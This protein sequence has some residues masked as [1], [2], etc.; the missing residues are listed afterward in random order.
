M[1]VGMNKAAMKRWIPARATLLTLALFLGSVAVG[2]GVL[3]AIAARLERRAVS[4]F[5]AA[6]WKEQVPRSA[7]GYRDYDYPA[8]RPEGCYR[9]LAVG[10]S[11]TAGHGINFDDA[12]PK[13]LE[14]YLNYFGNKRRT[15]YQVLNLGVNGQSTPEEVRLIREKVAE[16]GPDLVILGYCLNDPEDT[17]QPAELKALQ[18]R[19]FYVYF[20]TPTTGWSGFLYRRSALYRLI[21]HRLFATMSRR[22]AKRYYQALYNDDY[23]GWQKSR[24]ALRELGEFSRQSG[25]PVVTVIFPLFFYGLGDDYPFATAH[26]KVAAVLREA[27]IPYLDLWESFKGLDAESLKAVPGIDP[28]PNEVGHR[29]A[30]EALWRW[31]ILKDYLPS[32]QKFINLV[33]PI[34]SPFAG[35]PA[36]PA[37]AASSQRRRK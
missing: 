22:G 13:R 24:A 37:R 4:P 14:R 8:A 17:G 30:A 23:P 32:R 36:E 19:M 11:Y 21:R 34:P 12:Y 1:Q 6:R 3:E 25:I 16:L 26:R 20:N 27:G 31:L 35:A 2:L 5:P 18:D 15:L 33:E 9:I 10:D 28:H 7:A 29:I